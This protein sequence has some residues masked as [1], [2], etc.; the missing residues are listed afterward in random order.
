MKSCVACQEEP[1]YRVVYYERVS[2]RQVLASG[3]SK[4]AAELCRA[5]FEREHPSYAVFIERES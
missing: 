3:L 4:E 1:T 5:C 2:V